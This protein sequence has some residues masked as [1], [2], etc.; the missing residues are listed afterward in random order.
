MGR[1]NGGSGTVTY[2][3]VIVEYDNT[4]IEYTHELHKE[5]LPDFG[6][7]PPNAQEPRTLV[8]TATSQG[9]VSPPSGPVTLC[10]V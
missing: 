3:I 10:F 7:C 9:F 2:A 8:V 6:A 5:L 4:A 1:S